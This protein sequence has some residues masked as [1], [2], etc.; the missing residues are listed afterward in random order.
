ML[1]TKYYLPQLVCQGGVQSRPLDKLILESN[2]P[3][4]MSYLIFVLIKL[5]YI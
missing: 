3:T 5:I 2:I 1:L 4:Y